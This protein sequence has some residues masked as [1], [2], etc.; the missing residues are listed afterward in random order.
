KGRRAIMLPDGHN[1]YLQASVAKDG[2]ISRSWVFRYQ[3]DEARHDMGLGS[4]HSLRLAEARE[5]AR[6]LRQQI[7]AGLDPL[8]ARN[9]Q[10]AERR[11]R[12]QAERATAARAQTFRQRA[13]RY[14]EV[15]GGKWKNAKH[16]GQW[17]SSLEKYVYPIIGDLNVAHIDEAHLVRVLQ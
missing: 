6:E 3:L 11:A 2:S 10:K 16:A 9:E 15:H 8:D 12:A 17:P 14:L 13:T 4:L 5:R 7:L 1:L